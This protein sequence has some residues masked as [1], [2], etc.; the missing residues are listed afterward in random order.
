M[1]SV[2][3]ML[4]MIFMSEHDENFI[5]FNLD[6][7]YPIE[8]ERL[9]DNNRLSISGYT[10]LRREI[11]KWGKITS[12]PEGFAIELSDAALDQLLIRLETDLNGLMDWMFISLPKR[13]QHYYQKI[14]SR[15][16]CQ[17]KNVG[18]N[19]HSL[20]LTRQEDERLHIS[21]TKIDD[22]QYSFMAA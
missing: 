22:I 20:L 13:R 10:L 18:V 14:E 3:N 5:A 8:W 17:Y 9:V 12:L 1:L 19:Q 7:P 6:L 11:Q 4:P 2:L 15:T 16:F 21:I